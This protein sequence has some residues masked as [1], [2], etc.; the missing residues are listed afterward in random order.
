MEQ[1]YGKLKIFFGYCA[2]VGKT[3][4]MLN[5]AQQK[6]V[7]GVDV[8]IGYIEPHD[9]KETTDLMYGLE[10]IEKKKIIYKNRVFYEFN[11]DTAL[12][13]HPELIL[14]DELAHTNVHGSRHKKRYSD[15]EELLRAG[16]DVYTTVNVQH[17]ESLYDIVESITRIKVNE[18]I[19]DHIFD[20]ADDVKLVDIEIDDLI[21]RLKEGKIYHQKQA[22]QNKS[23]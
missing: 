6:S 10:Q 17:L 14:V 19:P 20:D 3:Y 12:K 15:I 11:L 22:K 5:E 2:G 13:R 21:N 18:R 16:I 7:H 4:A 8:V 23:F 1:K 9:R